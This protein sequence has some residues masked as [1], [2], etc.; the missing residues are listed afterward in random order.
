VSS[1]SAF[2]SQPDGAPSEDR[3]VDIWKRWASDVPGSVIQEASWAALRLARCVPTHPSWIAIAPTLT[4]GRTRFELG[5]QISAP[6]FG[7]RV[8]DCVDVARY[9]IRACY[10]TSSHSRR[11]A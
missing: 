5:Y 7:Q 1:M 10:Q 9:G 2:D 3:A 6:S 4:K 11:T 8:I